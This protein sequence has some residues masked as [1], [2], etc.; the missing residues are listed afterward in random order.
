[1]SVT[2]RR[3]G[4]RARN[5]WDDFKAFIMRGNVVDLALAVVL[6]AAFGAIVSGFVEDILMPALINPV[7]SQTGTDWREA[8][9]GP[10]IRIGHFFGTIVDFLII[11]FVL[12]LVVKTYERFKRKEE[13]ETEPTTEEKLNA[14]LERLNAF[15]ESRL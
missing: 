13:V 10:G 7:L 9:V 14:T 8:V 1:M 4:S 11:A 12:F 5:F 3:V 15:L 2:G 6:G